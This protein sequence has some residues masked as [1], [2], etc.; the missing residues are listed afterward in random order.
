[1]CPN[2]WFKTLFYSLICLCLTKLW[3][4]IV[5]LAYLFMHSWPHYHVASHTSLVLILSVWLFSLQVFIIILIHSSIAFQVSSQAWYFGLH[6]FYLS[7]L[8][9]NCLTFWS[10]N[11]SKST[12]QIMIFLNLT[13]LVYIPFP[14][15]F[16]NNQ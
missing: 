13:C 3:I 14:Y 5:L 10:T 1:M 8:L 16:N 11:Q 4:S 2:S 6:L 15:H 9:V 12:N 7:W